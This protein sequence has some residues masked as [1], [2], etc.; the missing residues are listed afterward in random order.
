MKTMYLVMIATGS[1]DDYYENPE[2]ITDDKDAANVWVA[3]LNKIIN[4][5][6]GRL[7]NFDLNS[8]KK[9][10]FWYDNILLHDA[11]AQ[12]SEVPY[13]E[14]PKNLCKCI[15]RIGVLVG[16]DDNWFCVTCKKEVKK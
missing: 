16:N 15:S 11:Q 5:N 9:L 1:Y 4:E 12:I 6:R 7:R 14:F 8:S 13:R 3:R 10:P 2:F